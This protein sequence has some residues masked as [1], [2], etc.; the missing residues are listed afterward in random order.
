MAATTRVGPGFGVGKGVPKFAKVPP[1]P[2][3]VAD[4]R[5]GPLRA[6]A[7]CLIEMLYEKRVKPALAQV[8]PDSFIAFV[9]RQWDE[10]VEDVDAAER[11]IIRAEEEEGAFSDAEKKYHSFVWR[12]MT[13]TRRL[14]GPSAAGTVQ[15]AC[16]TFERLAFQVKALNTGEPR[17]DHVEAE[18][19]YLVARYNH[20]WDVGLFSLMCLRT[21]VFERIEPGSPATVEVLLNSLQ[22]AAPE[23][24]GAISDT[25]AL[26]ERATPIEL[27][28]GEPIP[29]SPLAAPSIH[30]D[31]APSSLDDETFIDY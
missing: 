24:D 11:L 23:A 4:V 25:F 3:D 16:T 20:A 13:A 6:A 31:S 1:V 21:I 14:W 17:L 10:F 28:F 29:P 9:D 26:R 7:R 8:A 15:A 12:M 22:W 2:L 18:R 5:D 30:G 27:E 19:D